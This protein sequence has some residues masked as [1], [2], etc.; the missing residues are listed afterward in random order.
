MLRPGAAWLELWPALTIG[1]YPIEQSMAAGSMNL[2]FSTSDANNASVWG[3]QDLLY[4]QR[5]AAQ[6]YL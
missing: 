5:T 4:F 6:W 2:W 3:T 1:C